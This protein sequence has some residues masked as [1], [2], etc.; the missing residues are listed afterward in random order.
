MKGS[1]E[2]MLTWLFGVEPSKVWVVLFQLVTLW[3]K[4][5]PRILPAGGYITPTMRSHSD[6]VQNDTIPAIGR[7][8]ERVEIC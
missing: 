1:Q 2:V 5:C 3:A 6:N 4:L 8:V 7:W